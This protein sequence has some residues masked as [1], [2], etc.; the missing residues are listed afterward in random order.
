MRGIG[1]GIGEYGNMGEGERG[2]G[3]EGERGLDR[4][5]FCR[6]IVI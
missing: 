6:P 1:I 3:G 2:S 5:R 4:E